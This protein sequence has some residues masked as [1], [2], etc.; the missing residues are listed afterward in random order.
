MKLINVNKGKVHISKDAA[1]QSLCGQAPWTHPVEH[2]NGTFEEVTCERCIKA[3]KR[4][5]GN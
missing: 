5:A 2:F 3:K 4:P 1:D